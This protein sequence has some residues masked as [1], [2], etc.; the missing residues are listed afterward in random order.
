M[1]Y[2]ARSSVNT[3]TLYSRISM[4]NWATGATVLLL[5]YAWSR[6]SWRGNANNTS[7]TLCVPVVAVSVDG[8]TV[9]IV[10][11]GSA[12]LSS[13]A[14]KTAS[15]VRNATPSTSSRAP[16]WLPLPLRLQGLP[17]PFLPLRLPL[18]R[19][20]PRFR[21]SSHRCSTDDS[22]SWLQL[23]RSVFPHK[24][25]WCAWT[26][27]HALSASTVR[28][29]CLPSTSISA[30]LVVFKFTPE[31]PSGI[32]S[33][34]PRRASNTGSTFTASPWISAQGS[35]SRG[36]TAPCMSD[37]AAARGETLWRVES[38]GLCG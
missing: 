30:T 31:A 25:P 17:R 22:C 36:T 4:G 14:A 12:E 20:A 1:R 27:F 11:N 33:K 29:A 7:L 24:L 6:S 19:T 5:L 16:W 32:P 38:H 35:D 23:G 34:A 10:R 28:A 13:S 3:A 37:S 8:I 21:C 9:H 2:W 18:P 15:F 26:C